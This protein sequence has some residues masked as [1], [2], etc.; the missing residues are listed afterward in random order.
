MYTLSSLKPMS[1]SLSEVLVSGSSPLL[2]VKQSPSDS[3]QSR[4]MCFATSAENCCIC[5]ACGG[6]DGGDGGG[7]WWFSPTT[8]GGGQIAPFPPLPPGLSF[9]ITF[10]RLFV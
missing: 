2:P 3:I 7:V 6:G 4:N 1:L 5:H 9:S 8:V 10:E